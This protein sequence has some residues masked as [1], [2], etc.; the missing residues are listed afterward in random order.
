MRRITLAAACVLLCAPVLGAEP[1]EVVS[2]QPDAVSITIYRDLFALITE[3][4]TVDLPEGPVTLA[5][6][7]VVETL[8]PQSAV[9]ADVG[10]ALEERNYD[11]DR[12]T[13]NNLLSKSIGKTV[14]VTRTFP[15]S[16]K[17]TQTRAVV[18]AAG[19]GGIT[20]QSEDG[21][22]ALHC[23]GIPERLTFDEVPDALHPNPRLSVR[24]AAGAAGKRTIHV[25]YLAQ[26]FA[27]KSDYVAHLNAT[28]DRMDLNGWVTLRNLTNAG[29]RDAQVQVVAGKLHLLSEYE[30]GTSRFGNTDNYRDVNELREARN[31]ALELMQQEASF[32][33]TPFSGCHASPAR[34]EYMF[35]RSITT[36]DALPRE[37]SME[38]A[39]V[40]VTGG[41]ASM[42]V[43][44]ELGDYQL[45]RLPWAT[46]LAARQTKQAV[47]LD[48]RGV[49]IN[50]FY[51][52]HFNPL[53]FE[54]QD[55]P[56]AVPSSVVAFD[57]KK[58]AGLGEPLPEG[59]FRMFESVGDGTVFI[60]EAQL[61]DKAVGLPVELTVARALDLQVIVSVDDAFEKRI[62]DVELQVMNAKGVPVNFEVRQYIEDETTDTKIEN[63]NHRVGRKFGDYAWRF[64]VP[65]NGSDSLTYRFRYAER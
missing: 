54:S 38:I 33:S 2:A 42:A 21:S 43:R 39:E 24:L 64:R 14:T 62:A 57:N 6:E 25:S 26:G 29:F 23:S 35:R 60:G 5:F 36:D 28:G 13:S 19:Y 18:V 61:A 32:V 8:I 59:V 37:A 45:Y 48:K 20:L 63:S 40:T 22:E 31:A 53:S 11:Y 15:G 10:R 41:R 7:G 51:A 46:D 9:V 30:R 4:R 49:K 17:V 34:G 16:G 44:E 1:V 65:A 12:L 27:W 55:N 50:R 52:F 3:T 56:F 58:S 47:F